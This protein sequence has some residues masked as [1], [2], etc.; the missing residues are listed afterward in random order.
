MD[1]GVHAVK[2]CRYT[3]RGIPDDNSGSVNR[4][5]N[6]PLRFSSSNQRFRE[7]LGFFIGILE[8]L[9]DVDLVWRHDP[10]ALSCDIGRAD[11]VESLPLDLRR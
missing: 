7:A 10:R 4:S 9:A 2:V 8:S 5:P 1:K 3:R 11:V 6:A